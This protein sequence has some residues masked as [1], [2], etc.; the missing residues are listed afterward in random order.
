MPYWACARTAPSRDQFAAESVALAGFEVFTPRVRERVGAKWRTT[1]L[2]P[3]YFFVRIVDQWRVL[4]RT[5]GVMRVVQ[6]GPEPA[7]CPDEVIGELLARADRDGIIR[8]SARR[9]PRRIFTPGAAV[10]IADG[11]L[12][13]LEAIHTG[14]SAH[15]REIVLLTMLGASR[16][17]EIAAGL[18]APR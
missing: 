5:V 13:G 14:M 9:P 7:R 17:I 12:R 16:P 2:F 1:P 4:N 11:P 6:F 3:G 15:D 18:L 10:A 8:L